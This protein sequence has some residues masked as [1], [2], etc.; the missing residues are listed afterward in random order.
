MRGNPS[1]R[2][3]RRACRLTDGAGAA[4]RPRRARRVGNRAAGL[5]V[6]AAGADAATMPV[7]V[8]A[9]F[10]SSLSCGTPGSAGS[11]QRGGSDRAHDQRVS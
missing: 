2:P 7:V 6:S 3:G 9:T 4:N 11:A 5:A 1:A 8:A 10:D